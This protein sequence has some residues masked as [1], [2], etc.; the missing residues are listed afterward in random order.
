MTIQR[1]ELPVKAKA[2]RTFKDQVFFWKGIPVAITAQLAEFYGCEEGNITRNFNNNKERFKV[3]D[4][5]FRLIGRQVTDFIRLS[6]LVLSENTTVLI[7]WTQR[8]AARHAKMLRTEKAWEVWEEMEKDYF[9][10]NTRSDW[11]RVGD[12]VTPQML[13]EQRSIP[14]QKTNSNLINAENVYS[15]EQPAIGRA[16]AMAY[17]RK[18]C[19]VITE[20]MPSS[21]REQGRELGLPRRITCSAKGVARVV[22]PELACAR[23]LADLL[24]LDGIA[25]NVAFNVARSSVTTF[26]LIAESGWRPR[27][28][29]QR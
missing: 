14:H 25:E 22:Q 17:N 3:K 13:H 20:R 5:F 11:E 26:R 1:R 21:W 4:H 2:K 27:S 6:K 23:S 15:E 24:I 12:L 7:L 28:F 29:Q 8:G 16:K 10:K 9:E 18:N 19:M